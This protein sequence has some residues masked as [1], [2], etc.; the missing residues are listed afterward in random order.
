[1]RNWAIFLLTPALF[2]Q[3]A[4]PDQIRAAATRSI[5]LLQKATSGFYKTQDCIS[6]HH[7]SLPSQ[8]LE[9][10]RERGVPVDE[11][12][13]H[14]AVV[15]ALTHTPNLSSLDRMVQANLIIDPA[16]SEAAALVAESAVGGAGAPDRQRAARRRPL[17]DDRRA[18]ASGA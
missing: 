10:A 7:L 15:K 8:A 11:A 17:G 1:M 9:V 13:I 14:T 18:S 4:S 12:A 2:G 16:S 6:C 3:G 5:V